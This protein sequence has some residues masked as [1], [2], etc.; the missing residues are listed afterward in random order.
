MAGTDVTTTLTG[1]HTLKFWSVDKAGNVEAQKTAT[2]RYAV[3][4]STPPRL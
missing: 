4:A 1:S 2:S 3:A